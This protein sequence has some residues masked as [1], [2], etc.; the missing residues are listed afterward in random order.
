LQ[1]HVNRILG[2]EYKEAAGPIDGIFGPLTKQGVERLQ[3]ALNTILKPNSPLVI[4]GIVGPF[5]RAAINDS[6]GG[7]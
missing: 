7:M 2:S 4:D 5:T 1:G 3:E 6:C